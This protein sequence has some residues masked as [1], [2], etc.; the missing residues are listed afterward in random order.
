MNKHN[1]IKTIYDSVLEG[2]AG[3][4]QEFKKN[5]VIGVAV[6]SMLMPLSGC[7]KY[8]RT[9]S[10]SRE[11]IDDMVMASSHYEVWAN[12]NN[13]DKADHYLLIPKNSNTRMAEGKWSRVDGKSLAGIVNNYNNSDSEGKRT[14]RALTD[15]EGNVIGYMWGAIGPTNL[16]LVKTGETPEGRPTYNIVPD[17]DSMADSDSSSGDAG[18]G[19]GGGAG[20]SG[21]GG[22]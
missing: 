2:L 22:Y 11:T 21:G 20:G 9:Q 15:P 19:G 10:Q 16:E 4:Y 12:H 3:K 14:L 18:G 5:A 1:P 6:A 13:P 17:Q 7:P 8:A